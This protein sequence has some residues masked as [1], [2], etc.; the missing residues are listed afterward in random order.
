MTAIGSITTYL[1]NQILLAFSTTASA[2][3]GVYFKLNSFF[4]MP[5]FGLNNAVVPIV[6]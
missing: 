6:A 3:Y 5:L 1:M 2:V 4:F